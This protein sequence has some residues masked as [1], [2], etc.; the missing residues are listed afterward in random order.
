MSVQTR[1][2]QLE[3]LL[4]TLK[5]LADLEFTLSTMPEEDEVSFAEA[6]DESTQSAYEKQVEAL[7]A[8]LKALPYECESPEEM[9]RVLERIVSMICTAAKAKNWMVLAPWDGALQWRV[10]SIAHTSDCTHTSNHAAGC[11][12][13]T[14]FTSPHERSLSPFTMSCV[15]C[16]ASKCG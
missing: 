6:P 12:W 2:H 4:D 5:S 3:G 16:L 8:Y 14:P 9:H 11:C 7:E 15:V 1:S 10:H 13:D